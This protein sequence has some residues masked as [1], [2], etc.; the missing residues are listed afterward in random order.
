M[1]IVEASPGMLKFIVHCLVSD[2]LVNKPTAHSKNSAR[3]RDKLTQHFI[4]F[5][6]PISLFKLRLIHNFGK[7]SN[8]SSGLSCRNCPICNCY[9]RVQRGLLSFWPR[10]SLLESISFQWQKCMKH[11]RVVI[12]RHA[13]NQFTLPFNLLPGL[14]KIISARRRIRGGHVVLFPIFKRTKIIGQHSDHPS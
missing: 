9:A 6:F 1:S 4:I 3:I 11:R 2:H 7:R 8:R 5:V 12:K 13:I 14:P 10:V